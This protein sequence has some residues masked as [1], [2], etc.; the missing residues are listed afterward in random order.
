MKS[1]FIRLEN[2]LN[3]AIFYVIMKHCMG[4]IITLMARKTELMFTSSIRVNGL[5]T[6]RWSP[7]AEG[8][9][10]IPHDKDT[11]NDRPY[12]VSPF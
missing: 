6:W 8:R 5:R 10:P 11:G 4:A 7:E 9:R 12:G 1:L 2:D 3:S